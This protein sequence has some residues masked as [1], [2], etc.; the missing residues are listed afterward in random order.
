MLQECLLTLPG[1]SRRNK[2]DP[3]LQLPSRCLDVHDAFPEQIQ[4]IIS[5]CDFKL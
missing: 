5:N 3:F 2:G 1:G 4:T